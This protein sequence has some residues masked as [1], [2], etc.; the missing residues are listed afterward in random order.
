MVAEKVRGTRRVR[1]ST[2]AVRPA[3]VLAYLSSPKR[4]RGPAAAARAKNAAAEAVE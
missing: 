3:Q 1:P 2:G 4:C